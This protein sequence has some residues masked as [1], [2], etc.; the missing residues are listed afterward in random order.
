MCSAVAAGRERIDVEGLARLVRLPWLRHGSMPDWLR[1]R[2]LMDL[3]A[4][5]LDPGIREA[6]GGLLVGMKS[7]PALPADGFGLTISNSFTR[8]NTLLNLLATAT[9]QALGSPQAG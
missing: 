9:R 8:D 1:L 4:E 6:L 5:R 2:L 3:S 7:V